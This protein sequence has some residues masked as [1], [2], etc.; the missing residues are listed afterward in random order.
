LL[1][2]NEELALLGEER[3]KIKIAITKAAEKLSSIR[4]K[5]SPELGKMIS[6]Q[7]SDLGFKQSRFEIK[8]DYKQPSFSSQ[9]R[10][11]GLIQWNFVFSKS[12][13][14]IKAVTFNSLFGRTCK[15]YACR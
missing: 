4:K 6:R 14:T 2:R 10:Q 15:S 13:R 7:I 1:R 3:E 9:F 5:V 12:R 11:A 8:V